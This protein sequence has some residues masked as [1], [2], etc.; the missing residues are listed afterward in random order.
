[1]VVVAFGLQRDASDRLERIE[2]TL[3]RMFSDDRHAFDLAMSALVAGAA[4]RSVGAE[5]RATD[6]RVNEAEREIRRELVVH[7]SV[8]GG[9]DT[10]AVLV[11]MSIVKDVER[12]GDYAK[13]LFDLANDGADLSTTAHADR[14]LQLRD[15][16]SR[17]IVDVAEA[18]R[19]RDPE[20]SRQ[21]LTDG[22]ALLDEFD[23]AVSALVRAEPE[24]QQ[25]VAQALTYR[26]LKRIVAHLLNVLSAVVMPVDRL[27]YFDE[28]P[29]DRS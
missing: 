16:V 11:Y 7:A 19:D 27:D 9:I 8:H 17:Q 20:R 12:V 2:A 23:A 13:N 14:Y 24:G 4:P 21:L 26:Y 25:A 1:V 15:D 29:E 3:Q 10:P 18:F 5:L 6:H 28:D 22:D